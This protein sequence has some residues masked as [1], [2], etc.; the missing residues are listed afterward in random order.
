[1]AEI[2]ETIL[3]DNTLP[4][5]WKCPRCGKVNAFRAESESIFIEFFKVIEHCQSCGAPHYWELRLTE[6]FKRKV[7]DA[8]DKEWL[9]MMNNKRSGK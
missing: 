6:S 7:I 1:M 9:D 5:R 8:M 2:D 3:I 4:K